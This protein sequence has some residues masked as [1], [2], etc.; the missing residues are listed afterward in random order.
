MVIHQVWSKFATIV[1]EGVPPHGDHRPMT[2]GESRALVEAIV[3]TI[4]DEVEKEKRR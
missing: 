2:R 1:E 4:A 3:Y